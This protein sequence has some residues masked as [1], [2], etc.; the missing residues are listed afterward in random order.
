M[1]SVKHINH[2]TYHKTKTKYCTPLLPWYLWFAEVTGGTDNHLLLWDLKSEGLSGAKMEKVCEEASIIVYLG[3]ELK[4]ISSPVCLWAVLEPLFEW[5]LGMCP[6]SDTKRWQL[7]SFS[8][9]LPKLVLMVRVFEGREIVVMI[10][11]CGLSSKEQEHH[12]FRCFSHFTWRG[13]FRELCY[14]HSNGGWGW[15]QEDWRI[16][17]SCQRHCHQ[18]SEEARSLPWGEFVG[19]KLHEVVF[20]DEFLTRSGKKLAKF[21]AALH[22]TWLCPWMLSII[23]Y[24]IGAWTK[25][26]LETCTD[27]SRRLHS[28]IMVTWFACFKT[29]AHALH[30]YH[31]SCIPAPMAEVW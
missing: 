2:I 31:A 16:P 29:H 3:Q 23:E 20:G 27:S 11:G 9:G 7:G 17:D 18:Y 22:E 25:S 28:A 15:L 5:C 1:T 26:F 21:L 4:V 30:M 6:R 10:F 19:M 8:F 14:D 13:A 12:C 24:E